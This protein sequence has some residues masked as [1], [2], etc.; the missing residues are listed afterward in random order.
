MAL[1]MYRQ[2][3]KTLAESTK[4]IISALVKNAVG[5]VGVSVSVGAGAALIACIHSDGICVTSVLLASTSSIMST[6]MLVHACIVLTKACD[7]S[8]SSEF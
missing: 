3:I 4:N 5:V 8:Q 7:G 6:T 1:A 2:A